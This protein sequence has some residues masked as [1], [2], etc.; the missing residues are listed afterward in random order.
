M[1]WFF[2]MGRFP[3]LLPNEEKIWL[4][5]LQIYGDQ[6]E[7]YR[8][9][10]RVGRGVDPGPRYEWKWRKLAI[11]LTQKRIDVVAERDGEVWI[12][13]VKPDAGLSA[14]GQVLSYRVLYREQFKEKRPIKLAIVTTRVDDDIREVA[15]EYGIV[16]YE[17]GYF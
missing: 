15:K 12:F 5:F 8:Y 16:V 10:V 17:L 3:H 14:I 13:E 7:N 2:R 1:G 11:M 6:F 4:R 9:D